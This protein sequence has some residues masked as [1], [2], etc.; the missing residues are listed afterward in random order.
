MAGLLDDYGL[1]GGIAEGFKEGIRAYQD[2]KKIQRDLEVQK[3]KLA[4]EENERK[5]TDEFRRSQLSQESAAKGLVELSPGKWEKSA[6]TKAQEE[7][8][9]K[10]KRSITERTLGLKE[11]SFE[12]KA[13]KPKAQAIPGFEHDNETEVAGPE[14]RMLRDATADEK[15]A[16]NL[17]NNIINLAKN[18]SSKDLLDPTSDINRQIKS[19]ASQAQ[20]TYKGDSFA[21]LGVLTGPDLGILNS[22]IEDPTKLVSIGKGKEGTLKLLENLKKNISFGVDAK[23]AS[24]GF[25]RKAQGIMATPTPVPTTTPIP[26]GYTKVS[27][28]KETLT[29]PAS[30]IADAVKDGYQEVK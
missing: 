16:N 21:K 15:T 17:L 1:I 4:F 18:A 29:I 22:I 27:N 10:Y 8:D 19:E 13:N 30:N 7:E 23:M 26:K 2:Q 24:R 3:Q 20:L 5:K 12:T 9:K 14:I 28:G 11:K 25:S 6:E